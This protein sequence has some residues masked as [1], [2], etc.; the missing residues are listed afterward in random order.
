MSRGPYRWT[1]VPY[2]AGGHHFIT[3]N[4]GR[5][6]SPD[7]LYLLPNNQARRHAFEPRES[8]G[9]SWLLL[10]RH[11]RVELRTP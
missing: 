3:K 6:F 4:G 2:V 8:V 9:Y 10:V 7:S 5:A 11:R 1:N